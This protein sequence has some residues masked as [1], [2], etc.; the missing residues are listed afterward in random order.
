MFKNSDRPA[1]GPGFGGR[2]FAPGKATY[3]LNL[4]EGP[5]P[6]T[7]NPRGETQHSR[8]NARALEYWKNPPKTDPQEIIRLA[9]LYE[10]GVPAGAVAGTLP[11]TS[12]VER[13]HVHV[14][15]RISFQFNSSMVRIFSS[16]PPPH[17]TALDSHHRR[18]ALA[19]F[20]EQGHGPVREPGPRHGHI[21]DNL[22]HCP[23]HRVCRGKG[24]AQ[25]QGNPGLRRLPV[26]LWNALPCLSV[27]PMH[28]G[29]ECAHCM[30]DY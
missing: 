5:N 17:A 24:M 7:Q 25:T 16:T 26:S 8:Q 10:S 6:L 29:I 23:E 28:E 18:R 3:H 21:C 22:P 1:F 14:S 30:Y 20:S 13:D 19:R 27:K 2:E 11:G 4:L 12:S 9:K 15:C